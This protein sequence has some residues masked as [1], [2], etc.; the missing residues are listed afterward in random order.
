MD[1]DFAKEFDR[2]FAYMLDSFAKKYGIEKELEESRRELQERL[3]SN[4]REIEAWVGN[5]EHRDLMERVKKSLSTPINIFKQ[6]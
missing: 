3:E 2:K 5:D 4:A 1:N 6:E